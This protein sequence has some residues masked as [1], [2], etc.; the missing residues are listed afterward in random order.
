[1]SRRAGHGFAG[2]LAPSRS[3]PLG[4]SRREIV[5]RL[6]PRKSDSRKVTCDKLDASIDAL[7][8]VTSEQMSESRGVPF[9]TKIQGEALRYRTNWIALAVTN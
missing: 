6:Q 9:M 3:H 5:A 4:M 8:R 7:W 2:R 1:M